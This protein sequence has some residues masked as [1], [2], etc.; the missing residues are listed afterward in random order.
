MNTERHLYI[1]LQT[2]SGDNND[3][4]SD[5]LDLEVISI[6]D[7]TDNITFQ[8]R[9]ILILIMMRKVTTTKR[10]MMFHN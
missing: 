3:T 10:Q 5:E 8:S 4:S 6:A 9:T 1:L 2:E 7:E